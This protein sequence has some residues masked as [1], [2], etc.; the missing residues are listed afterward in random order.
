MK[1]KVGILI[2]S[3][4]VGGVQ[5][6]TLNLVKQ[7]LAEHI[8]VVVVS[9]GLGITY[10]QLAAIC[11]T[12]HIVHADEQSLKN[13]L[14]GCTVVVNNNWWSINPIMEKIL[15][16]LG[17]KYMEAIHGPFVPYL[18]RAARYDHIVH[19]YLSFSPL[20]AHILC[21]RFGVSKRKI[22][23]CI[24]PVK[25]ATIKKTSESNAAARKM[26]RIADD[27]FVVGMVSRISPEKGI[28][29]ALDI[30]E[31]YHKKNNKAVF[32]LLGGDPLGA[33]TYNNQIEL[34]CYE[35]R[36][37]GMFV[38]VTGCIDPEAV[39][40]LQCCFD[41]ALNTSQT[42]GMSLSVSELF[43]AGIPCLFPRYADTGMGTFAMSNEH[44]QFSIP[45]RHRNEV[46]AVQRMTAA[47]IESYVSRIDEISMPDC[48]EPR[49]F[50]V[51]TEEIIESI[52]DG[53]FIMTLVYNTP[54]DWFRE[55]TTS[56]LNQKFK[57]FRWVI[58]DDGNNNPEILAHLDELSADDRVTI[59]RH[60]TNKNIREA[61]NTALRHMYK[62]NRRMM[63]IFDSDDIASPDLLGMQ[64]MEMLSRSNV[65]VL[66][67]QIK[68]FGNSSTT[69]HHP[70]V[71]TADMVRANQVYPYW[72]INNPGVAIWLGNIALV[73]ERYYPEVLIP[74]SSD[75][76]M[77]IDLL[78]DGF[79]LYNRPEVLVQYRWM[80]KNSTDRLTPEEK[81]LRTAHLELIKNQLYEVKN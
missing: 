55:M 73:D 36:A 58:V 44:E 70:E 60:D 27:A 19:E 16:S 65:C 12:H 11:E 72:F 63:M 64:F 67:V 81:K 59:L 61:Q 31:K 15:P 14:N 6:V 80:G 43:S 34:R 38:K 52:L 51:I 30:F 49:D 77:W 29:D 9:G 35:L 78:K 48:I 26:L 47:E 62:Y 17:C 21:T 2:N 66:G 22:R 8:D 41:V 37:K 28:I 20:G 33:S 32:V 46:D 1:N 39:E 23:K 13:A 56:I 3:A 79:K 10:Y 54:I 18:Q 74:A 76:A 57:C 75:Y 45:V 24:T 53:P 40:A 4:N 42:E 50:R 68:F 25:P 5:N 69:T 71:V 7:M